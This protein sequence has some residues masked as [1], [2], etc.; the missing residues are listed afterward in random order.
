M[1]QFIYIRL[2]AD[3]SMDTVL[4][5]WDLRVIVRQCCRFRR[6][7]N[8]LLQNE[9]IILQLPC[10]AASSWSE[11]LMKVMNMIERA[12]KICVKAMSSFGKAKAVVSCHLQK[13]LEQIQALKY[14]N[15]SHLHKMCSRIS[16]LRLIKSVF[17]CPH[18]GQAH[19]LIITADSPWS[20]KGTIFSWQTD[21]SAW[22]PDGR[23]VLASQWHPVSWLLMSISCSWV[24]IRR[25]LSHWPSCIANHFN[26]GSFRSSVSR[27]NGSLL[28]SHSGTSSNLTWARYHDLLI[29]RSRLQFNL[30]LS[31]CFAM[32]MSPHACVHHGIQGIWRFLMLNYAPDDLWQ[33]VKVKGIG[34]IGALSLSCSGIG[35]LAWC[36]HIG[37]QNQLPDNV[38]RPGMAPEPLI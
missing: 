30:H 25:L 2:H 3:L 32:M 37:L 4:T 33:L 17:V 9:A 22:S 12:C 29:R 23:L 38:I 19:C 11:V 35:V 8:E 7:H 26:D 21:E 10:T 31:L 36:L 27:Y 14:V 18:V 34:T 16:P 28:S 24:W 15:V 20:V 13:V 5:R 6:A 1:W